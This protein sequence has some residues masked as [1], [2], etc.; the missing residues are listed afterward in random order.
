MKFCG[1]DKRGGRSKNKI[2]HQCE[3]SNQS[4]ESNN[5]AEQEGEKTAAAAHL[6]RTSLLPL[7]LVSWL[8]HYKHGVHTHAHDKEQEQR[9]EHE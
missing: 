4:Q 8:Y 6:I 2:N 3:L 5:K 1:K 7:V 9:Q